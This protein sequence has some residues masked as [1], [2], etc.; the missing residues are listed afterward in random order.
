MVIVWQVGWP[1]LIATSRTP[2]SWPRPA[3]RWFRDHVRI[4]FVA[5]KPAG[6]D[7]SQPKA[8]RVG[9]GLV[10]LVILT[11]S[12]VASVSVWWV[13]AYLALMVLIFVTPQRHRQLAQRRKPSEIS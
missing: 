5:G 10:A 11:S 13:P 9:L 1:S 2:K 4:H 3:R 12:A 6:T 8:A 7:G